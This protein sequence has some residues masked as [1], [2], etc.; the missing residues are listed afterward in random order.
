[1]GIN[2]GLLSLYF[3]F[4]VGFILLQLGIVSKVTCDYLISRSL[5]PTWRF[6][7]VDVVQGIHGD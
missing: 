5:L 3:I 2:Y 1:M 6:I 7:I 4:Y